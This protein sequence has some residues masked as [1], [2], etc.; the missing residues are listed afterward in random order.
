MQHGQNLGNLQK[1]EN[2]DKRIQIFRNP[3]N[4]GPI[5]NWLKCLDISSGEYIKVL[6]SDDLLSP[7][8]VEKMVSMFSDQVGFVFS[9]ARIFKDDPQRV[10]RYDLGKTGNYHSK[11]FIYESI[12][13]DK[14]PVSPGAAILEGATLRNA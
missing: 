1:L 13:A 5:R 14:F 9:K 6:F 3:T 4:I 8:C 2:L 10:I 11:D 12:F 7:Y